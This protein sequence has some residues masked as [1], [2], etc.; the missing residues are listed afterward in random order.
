VNILIVDDEA[1]ARSRL[2][3]L[4][5]DCADDAIGSVQ[6][7]ADALQAWGI[8]QKNAIDLVMLD[9]H[10][11]GLNGLGLAQQIQSLDAPPNIIFVTAHP[12]HALQAFDLQAIDY[13]TKPVRLERL[14]QA[15]NKCKTLLQRAQKTPILTIHERGKTHRVALD[16]VLYVKAELKYLTVRTV[17]KAYLLEGALND[18]EQKY[19]SRFIRIHRNALVARACI[20]T[21]EKINQDDMGENWVVRVLGVPDALLV[22]RRQ[23]HLVRQ[24]LKATSA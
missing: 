12:E 2:N 18:L 13:L 3:T 5:G 10:M 14:Q 19:A 16:D 6:Q 8:L 11:P 24:I 4:L 9:I 17:E 15:L 20:Q 23:L 22:S 7:A 21:L 1:L